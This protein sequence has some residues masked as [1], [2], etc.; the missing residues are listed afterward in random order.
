MILDVERGLFGRTR[1]LRVRLDVVRGVAPAAMHF[2]HAGPVLVVA[3]VERPISVVDAMA[4]A[5]AVVGFR[6]AR[7]W[8]ARDTKPNISTTP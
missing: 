6:H 8:E 4:I 1:V 7:S 5:C 2:D 3:L